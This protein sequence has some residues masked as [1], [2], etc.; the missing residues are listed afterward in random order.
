MSLHKITLFLHVTGAL[1]FGAGIFLSLL[2]LWVLRR[3]QRVEQVRSTLELLSLS[4]PVIG[5]S[6]LVNI[7]T[8]LYM[9]ANIWGWQVAWIIV[10][11]VGVGLYIATGA[12][13][14]MRRNRITK[15]V[16]EMPDGPVSGT[17]KQ[18]T[19]DPLIGTSV[20]MMVALVV[21]IVF[22]MTVKPALNASILAMVATG[23]IAIVASLPL[24]WAN[25]QAS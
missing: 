10:A 6:M 23:G 15:L 11:I 17:V 25:R 1:G 18:A 16:S 12:V 20:Y 2:S 13:M 8:G 3:A 24:W 4:G 7:A 22:L 19:H 5:T 14:G 21:G 9:T